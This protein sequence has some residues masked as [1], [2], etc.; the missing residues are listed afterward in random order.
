M[1]NTKRRLS[2]FLVFA[3]I[4]SLIQPSIFAT[5]MNADPTTN[6][7]A[8]VSMVYLGTSTGTQDFNGVGPQSS[9]PDTDTWV[10]QEEATADPSKGSATI[11]WVGISLSDMKK[12]DATAANDSGLSSHFS[13]YA[14]NGVY[15]YAQEAGI[16]N[17]AT[18]LEYAS[19]YIKP[20]YLNS[21]QMRNNAFQPAII[22]QLSP[23]FTSYSWSNVSL[24]VNIMGAT[25]EDG[26]TPSGREDS[27]IDPA[28]NPLK[29]YS[30]ITGPG[31]DNNLFG[32]TD[33]L[34][35][36]TYYVLAIPFTFVKRPASGTK[37]IQAALNTTDFIVQT[38]DNSNVIW[39][40]QWNKD[41]GTTSD[42]NLKNHFNYSGDLD[43]FPQKHTVTFMNDTTQVDSVTVP[44]NGTVDSTKIPDGT[45]LNP[46][47]AGQVFDDWYYDP[48]G[49]NTFAAATT[50]FDSTVAITADTTVFAKFKDPYKI[51]FNSNY[52]STTA[53]PMP[54]ETT[55]VVNVAPV[56]SPGATMNPADQPTASDFPA[57][58]GYKFKEWQD[59]ATNNV[60]DLNTYLFTG[61]MTLNAIW[62]NKIAITFDENFGAGSATDEIEVDTNNHIPAASVPKS[63]YEAKH[64][65][66]EIVG[67]NTAANGSGTTVDPT[68]ANITTSQTLYAQWQAKSTTQPQVTLTFDAVGGQLNN[69]TSITVKSGDT[70]PASWMPAD[71]TKTAAAAPNNPY[72]FNGWYKTNA[73]TPPAADKY[74]FTNGY[75]LNADETAYA[76]WSYNHSDKVTI[77]FDKNGGDTDAS[78]TSVDIG[79]GDKVNVLPAAPTKAG[80][81]FNKWHDAATGGT[82]VDWANT[83]FSANTTVYANW[84]ANITIQ[85]NG[86]GATANV[87]Q[88]TTQPATATY[89]DPSITGMTNSDYQFVGWNTKQN[90]SGAY[91]SSPSGALTFGDVSAL[92]N[93]N[94]TVTLYAQWAAVPP[95][96]EPPVQ[97]DTPATP[98]PANKGVIVTFD[99]NVDASSTHPVAS[100]SAPKHKYPK[101]DD[102]I[103]TANMPNEPTRVQ[104]PGENVAPYVFASWNTK[105]DGSGTP[106]DGN[107]NIGANL[108]DDLKQIAG[109][110]TSYELKLYAQWELDPNYTGPKVTVTFNHNDDGKGADSINIPAPKQIVQGDTLG[111]DIA[112]PVHAGADHAKMEFKGWFE[113]DAS[114]TAAN[115]NGRIA[116]DTSKPYSKTTPITANTTFYAQWYGELLVVPEATSAPYTGSQIKPTYTIKQVDSSTNPTNPTDVT[117]GYNKTNQ[118]LSDV[119]NGP[120]YVEYTPVTAGATATTTLQNVGNYTV[121][122]AFST[123]SPLEIMGYEIAGTNPNG[124]IVTPTVFDIKVDPDTQLQDSASIAPIGITDTL[125]SGVSAASVY[126][127]NY[128]KWTDDAAADGNIQSDH[129]TT[130][131]AELGVAS[132]STP[133]DTAFYAVEIEI[134]DSNYK[135]GT[136]T[137]SSQTKQVITYPATKN[138]DYPGYAFSSAA[139]ATGLNIVYQISQKFDIKIKPS[140]QVQK[141]GQSAPLNIQDTLPAGVTASDVYDVV[142][143]QGTVANGA[144]TPSNT[145]TT[146][147]NSSAIAYYVV[148]IQPKSPLYKLNAVISQ[149]SDAVNFYSATSV[150]SYT[151]SGSSLGKNI[152]YQIEAND[153]G[154]DGV[155]LIGN[156]VIRPTMAPGSTTAP[157]PI[158]T[159]VPLSLK[160]SDYASPKPFSTADPDPVNNPNQDV[161]YV[162]VDKDTTS[163]DFTIDPKF[164][165][166]TAT[167]TAGKTGTTASPVTPA[168]AW[169]NTTKVFTVNVPITESGQD[170]TTITVTMTAAD[171]TTTRDY[172]FIVQKLQEGK[173]ELAYGNSPVGMIMKSTD[174]TKYPTDADKQTAIN[175]FKTTH[176][177]SDVTNNLDYYTVAWS[178]FI[179][180]GEN[181]T[182]YNGDEDP[183]AIFIYQRM[184]FRD[185]GFTATDSEGNTVPDTDVSISLDLTSYKGGFA[186][187]AASDNPQTVSASASGNQHLF[188]DFI[189]YD[190]RPDVYD[191]TYTFTD[192][193]TQETV[194]EVR[195]VIAISRVG[196]AEIDGN[197]A[198]NNID[199]ST[200]T[201]NI[202]NFLLP[203]V[204]SL[205]KYRVADTLIDDNRAVNN[206]D[207]SE[208]MSHV[209]SG[210]LSVFYEALPFN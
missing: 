26:S 55:K 99:D 123:N 105:P 132:T 115:G 77:T 203:Q 180:K 202:S 192:P 81:V 186:M 125:P 79:P 207:A 35:D 204:N 74:D 67:W 20:A 187:Y 16:F 96:Q 147:T 110:N 183:T 78:P 19:T 39:K 184:A 150:P 129:S 169:N 138:N 104:L 145:T 94:T 141:F 114:A 161:Y 136:V 162:R 148:E 86:N 149:D 120:I 87:P 6:S 48:A 172:T 112:T 8:T 124:M 155:S 101:Y 2:W 24:G 185:P 106:V 199:A 140:E 139:A 130:T 71:P 41:P 42:T 210:G 127:V 209:A 32:Y 56:P 89:T 72:T 102:S 157:A 63:K 152:L 9:M 62:D 182:D 109:T 126:K 66:Y 122:A 7:R 156:T 88:A 75:T 200:I 154:L 196:D 97:S 174:L 93:N 117:G 68:T 201:S 160:E 50:K 33:D 166:T 143:K 181:G 159:T 171:G 189:G 163:I 164:D 23:K 17:I 195:K 52:A 12:M 40:A 95:G 5:D 43:L 137:S 170:T 144:F 175:N 131:G 193:A 103:G 1:K 65:D 58:A 31:I 188:T 198:V 92:D 177:F 47:V 60:I 194:T 57:P 100:P 197:S 38:G 98:N 70:I 13:P 53:N 46:P 168:P 206:L 85:Y 179:G 10:S 116:F 107:T 18:G 118:D 135:L 28:D 190:I 73:V 80:S 36:D 29:V 173:I 151:P 84:A 108:G 4:M 61:D 167:A 49:S 22:K 133:T 111:Y 165:T 27:I 11:F 76:N 176:K 25:L 21:N 208:I 158:P 119:T 91:V 44:D 146:I 15:D 3:M 83:T 205:Y 30:S 90:G 69:P 191:M 178:S 82:E 45:T 134:I 142:Y 64:S 37:V 153:P 34:N 51:T 14:N 121:R 128:R 113:Q 54:Q 59:S